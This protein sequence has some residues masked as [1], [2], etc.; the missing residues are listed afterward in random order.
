MTHKGGPRDTRLIDPMTGR[1]LMPQNTV[2][3]DQPNNE[4]NEESK[5]NEG[6]VES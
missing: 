6:S 4:E 2:D 1:Y 5:E 3:N